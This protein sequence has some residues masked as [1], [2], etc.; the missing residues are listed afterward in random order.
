MS[1]K[2]YSAK[3]GGRA[4][5]LRLK[6]LRVLFTFSFYV[7][8]G[9]WSWNPGPLSIPEITKKRGEKKRL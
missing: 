7:Y 4:S 1:E 3:A 9:S 8:H 6:L 2:E 5:K